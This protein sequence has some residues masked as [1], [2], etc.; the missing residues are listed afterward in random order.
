MK[1]RY[2][3]LCLVCFAVFMYAMISCSIAASRTS[4]V[5]PE[6]FTTAEAKMR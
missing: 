2:L 6:K 4:P 3:A 1:K 5:S